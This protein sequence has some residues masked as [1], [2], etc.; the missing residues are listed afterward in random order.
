MANAHGLR[1]NLRRCYT[2]CYTPSHTASIAWVFR[3]CPSGCYPQSHHELGLAT[4]RIGHRRCHRQNEGYARFD[5]EA[6]PR[7][8]LRTMVGP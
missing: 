8:L 3:T 1:R 7:S 4:G 2:R 6:T 5:W